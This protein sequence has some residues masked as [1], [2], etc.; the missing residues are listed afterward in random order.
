MKIYIGL[1]TV[2]A[3]VLFTA[4]SNFL[5]ENPKSEKASESF[6]QSSTDAY[7]IVNRLYKKGFPEKYNVITTWAGCWMMDG[8]Y[9]SGLFDNTYKGQEVWITHNQSLTV[10][11]TVDN[12]HLQGMWQGAYEAI[13]RTA[14][15]AINHIPECPGLSEEEKNRL[16]GEA[17]FFRALNYFYLVK[18]FGAVPIVT[19]TYTTIGDLYVKR[20]T[21]QKVYEFIV[22]DLTDALAMNLPDKPFPENGFRISRGSVAALLADVYLNMAGY[23]LKDE[24][25]YQLAA[26]TAQSLIDNGNYALIEHIDKGE[27]SAYNILRTSDNE[28]EYLYTIEY[29]AGIYDGGSRPMLC[30]PNVAGS[31]GE[32][33]WPD[34]NVA[35]QPHPILLSLYDEADDLR[36]QD[37]QY[38]HRSYQL[39]KGSQELKEFGKP[40]PYFWVEEEAIYETAI[41]VKDQTYYRLAEMYLIAAEA[42][43]KA[44]NRVTPEAIDYL[45]SIQARASIR[46][47]KSTLVAELTA[48]NYSVDE[49]IEEVWKEK[50]R[51]FIFEFKIWNDITRTRKYP[52][53]N[54]NGEVRFTDL[55]G[56][57]NPYGHV[58]NEKNIYYPICSQEMQRNPMLAEDPE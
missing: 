50:I 53:L 5:E 49:F 45:A 55:I 24:S 56:A 20:S 2:I 8:G 42:L 25:K 10:D 4:C 35:Y 38:F 27:N 7:S 47:D 13:V 30:F 15:F 52:A 21:E 12:N 46:K 17:K 23:P 22:R 39:R 58:F 37:R 18:A 48:K 6:F 40:L 54:A 57:S 1:L 29:T 19:T 26:Q 44:A 31:W 34:C 33:K 3:S 9:L 41:S 36:F 28:K 43:T 11:P 32:F 14:N 16:I 51:E